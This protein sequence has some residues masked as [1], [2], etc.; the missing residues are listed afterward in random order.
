MKFRICAALTLAVILAFAGFGFVKRQSYTDI[1]EEENYF[2]QL[3]VAELPEELTSLQCER[4]AGELP[5]APYILRVRVLGEIEFLFRTS[6]QRVCVEEVYAGEDI[7][8]G[9][10]ICLTG[11]RFA[12]VGEW[13]TAECDF[14]HIPRIGYEY[15]VFLGEQLDTLTEPIPVYGLYYVG[16]I[17]PVFCYEDFPHTIWPTGEKNTY[18]PYQELKENEFFAETEESFQEWEALKRKLLE[19]YPSSGT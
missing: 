6:R 18:V 5:D 8:A 17:A 11:A 15:L 7:K 13:L 19:A 3:L 16:V 10:E 4:M 14:V 2:D 1:R 12:R 9:D